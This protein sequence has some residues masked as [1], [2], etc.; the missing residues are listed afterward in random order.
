[1]DPAFE[2]VGDDASSVRPGV[3]R[4]ADEPVRC[5]FGLL[6]VAPDRGIRTHSGWLRTLA[7]VTRCYSMPIHAR[8]E[9]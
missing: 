6:A 1:M 3:L 2:D 5:P 8:S 9:R 4:P 7:K